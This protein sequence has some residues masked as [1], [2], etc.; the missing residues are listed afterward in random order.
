[1]P[2]HRNQYG[3]RNRGGGG[4]TSPRHFGRFWS[5]ICPIT[6]TYTTA[7][8]P[9][10]N[11]AFRRLCDPW[12]FTAQ[13]WSILQ[14]PLIKNKTWWNRINWN[15]L[16]FFTKL[17]VERSHINT[18]LIH[19]GLCINLAWIALFWISLLKTTNCHLPMSISNPL[20]K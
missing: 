10:K 1:M 14:F 5:K 18:C 6:W 9:Q 4:F 17:S 12:R 8:P 7:P 2:I 16:F 19:R 3:Q 11:P 15:R 13:F 20:L